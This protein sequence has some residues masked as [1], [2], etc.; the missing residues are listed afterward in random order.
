MYFIQV[1]LTAINICHVRKICWRRI[2][3][4]TSGFLPG[5]FYG[6]RSQAGNSPWDCKEM[7]PTLSLLVLIH[8]L[9]KK[10]KKK[11]KNF[12]ILGQ[13]GFPHHQKCSMC[14]KYFSVC[15]TYFLIYFTIFFKLYIPLPSLILHIARYSEPTSP[16]RTNFHSFIRGRV[17]VLVSCDCYNK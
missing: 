1:K 9:K 3:Q 10:K 2:W 6:S 5:E 4:P 11:K 17:G 14:S 13:R 8:F 15:Y 7:D 12:G 16:D